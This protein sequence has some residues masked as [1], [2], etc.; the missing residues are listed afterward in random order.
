MAEM[1]L[2]TEGVIGVCFSVM[3][4]GPVGGSIVVSKVQEGE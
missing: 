3:S 4:N 2:V 1:Y